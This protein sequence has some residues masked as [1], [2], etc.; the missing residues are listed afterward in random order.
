MDC[1]S[2]VIVLRTNNES[3]TIC[4]ELKRAFDVF[5]NKYHP[6]ELVNVTANYRVLYNANVIKDNDVEIKINVDGTTSVSSTNMFGGNS[7]HFKAKERANQCRNCHKPIK[8]RKILALPAY[9]PCIL[10]H[11]KNKCETKKTSVRSHIEDCL[12]VLVTLK[13]TITLVQKPIRQVIV[14][15]IVDKPMASNKIKIVVDG[16]TIFDGLP[17]YQFFYH[18]ENRRCSECDHFGFNWSESE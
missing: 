13:S 16:Q 18:T 1:S 9:K 11:V 12:N 14:T 8:P 17:V 7:F 5:D 15:K 3:T 6:A 2:A 10:I 4:D